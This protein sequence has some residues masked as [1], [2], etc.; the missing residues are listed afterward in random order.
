[1]NFIHIVKYGV[2]I[3]IATQNIRH[4]MLSDVPDRS[5]K[6]QI[7]VLYFDGNVL[8]IR[9]DELKNDEKLCIALME[10]IGA[11]LSV[12]TIS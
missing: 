10:E 9:S 8:E 1:M 2:N 7:E 12:Q 5:D 3:I 4:I 6:Y 11:L